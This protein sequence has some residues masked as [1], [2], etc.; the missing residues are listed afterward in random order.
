VLGFCRPSS[1]VACTRSTDAAPH[2]RARPSEAPREYTK[3]LGVYERMLGKHLR[4]GITDDQRFRFASLMSLAVVRMST[5]WSIVKNAGRAPTNRG[6]RTVPAPS[7]STGRP[8]IT[9][10]SWSIKALAGVAVR[11]RH[12]FRLAGNLL[13]AAH[14]DVGPFP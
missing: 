13:S 10:Y 12:S 6:D 2:G 5:S 4:L 11:R 3:Q 7:L 14:N 1:P 9:I 8:E